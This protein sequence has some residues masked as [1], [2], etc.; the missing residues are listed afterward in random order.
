MLHSYSSEG[1]QAVLAQHT[2][3]EA[4][5]QRMRWSMLHAGVL[6]EEPACPWGRSRTMGRRLREGSCVLGSAC[7][8]MQSISL[9]KPIPQA[10]LLNRRAPRLEGEGQADGVEAQ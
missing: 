8:S 4:K 7:A 2:R 5:R 9:D 1:A 6:P 3:F 10:Q